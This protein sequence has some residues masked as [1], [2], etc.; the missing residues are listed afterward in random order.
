MNVDAGYAGNVHSRG[1]YV[2]LCVV[3]RVIIGFVLR[4]SSMNRE[5]CT[6]A[7]RGPIYDTLMEFSAR[8]LI[9]LACDSSA[10]AWT[11]VTISEL[12]RSFNAV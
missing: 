11:C 3:V 7:E 9:C 2:R 8:W 12:V 1:A 10:R 4:V 5:F 6:V